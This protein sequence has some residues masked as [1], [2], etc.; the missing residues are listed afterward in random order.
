MHLLRLS[1]RQ[2]FPVHTGLTSMPSEFKLN[3]FGLDLSFISLLNQ[4]IIY[5]T[6]FASDSFVFHF[7]TFHFISTVDI[8]SR[9]E[10][11]IVGPPD[12]SDRMK[13]FMVSVP[14]SFLYRA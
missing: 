4:L 12:S 1:V 10:G 5:I 6:L 14:L 7:V 13:F 8:R 3:S 9:W 11:Q 2:R